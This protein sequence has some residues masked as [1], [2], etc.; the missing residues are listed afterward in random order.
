MM[1]SNKMNAPKK[2]TTFTLIVMMFASASF[3]QS[4][5][6]D[7]Y[8]LSLRGGYSTLQG[9]SN[10]R[11]P[12]KIGEG[13]VAGYRPSN[14][15]L[16]NLDISFFSLTNDT[17]ASSSF[18][19]KQDDAFATEKWKAYRIGFLASRRLFDLSRRLNY[20]LGLGGG[21]MNWEIQNPDSGFVKRVTGVLNQEI[22]YAASELFLSAGSALEFSLSSA[23]ALKWNLQVD[24]LS[25]AGAEFSEPFNSERG[26]WLTSS[27]L[28]VAFSFGRPTMKWP[29]DISWAATSD[30]GS[31]S[32]A[33]RDS[34]GDGVPDVR[35][36]CPNSAFGV[37]VDQLGCA[38]DSDG[39]GVADGLDDCPNTNRK[40]MG[41]VDVHGCPV[42]SDLDGVVDYL[43]KCPF[44]RIGARVDQDGC[45]IDSDAD[46]VPDGLDD[47]PYTLVGVEVDP[48]GCID[49][50]MLSKTLVLNIDYS[51]GS[52][53][54]DYATREKL[55]RLSRLLNFV[56]DIKLEISG[57][58]DNIGTV[59]ANRSLSEK[60][61]NRVRDFL[62][63][64]GIASERVKV[65]GRG[66]IN[67][68]ASN[69]SAEGRARNRRVEIKF[70]H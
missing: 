27:M 18:T 52:F 1:R 54:I 32:T 7:R 39:D 13:F 55:V 65:F 11:Y 31:V 66:E 56:E 64:Q 21:L 47:C 25:G 15:W 40:A 67:F 16:L 69:N 29:S 22:D 3:S 49:L 44:N 30:V 63:T 35:D 58:T 62:V 34:D 4:S 45:P 23:L 48:N 36:E 53:E 38:R 46:G 14:R 2:I 60:R 68:V 61:A 17:T 10:G 9:N 26:R 8:Q 41:T 50:A 70:Y 6:Y 19:L 59:P 28:T 33:L 20:S 37:G 57:F 51:S 42:D 43:D 5:D 24:Y 12:L